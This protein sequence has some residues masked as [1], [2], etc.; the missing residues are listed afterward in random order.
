MRT[1]RLLSLLLLCTVGIVT[2]APERPVA[3]VNGDD[4][5]QDDIDREAAEIRALPP[6]LDI[7]PKDALTRLVERTLFAQAAVKAGVLDTP[8]LKAGLAKA[9]PFPQAA[10]YLPGTSLPPAPTPEARANTAAARNFLAVTY[11]D[12]R[13]NSLPPISAA[14]IHAFYEKNPLLFS[15]RHVYT[16]KE[17]VVERPT[18]RADAL[19]QSHIRGGR[20][21]D[22]LAVALK[23]NAIA[24]R[25]GQGTRKAEEMPMDM[26]GALNDMQAGHVYKNPKAAPG[27]LSLMSLETSVLEPVDEAYA[28]P[29]IERYLFNERRNALIDPEAAALRERSSITVREPSAN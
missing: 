26:L 19:V 7:K 25:G 10:V 2:A 9:L 22:E 17:I 8:A 3:T 23:S 4:I 13:A 15:N 21:I 1:R 12:L 16:V 24:F 28:A 11:L 18:P 27:T 6:R 20:S 29:A 14:Q 5:T